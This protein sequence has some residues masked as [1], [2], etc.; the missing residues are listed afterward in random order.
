MAKQQPRTLEEIEREKREKAAMLEAIAKFGGTPT[1]IAAGERTT[2]EP[3]DR[4]PNTT[5]STY[6]AEA[7]DHHEAK[8]SGEV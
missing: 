1:K 2:K 5:S 4:K 7:L 6:N 8:F 3:R